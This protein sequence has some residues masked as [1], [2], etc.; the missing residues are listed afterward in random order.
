MRDGKKFRQQNY[1]LFKQHEKNVKYTT[2][3]CQKFVTFFEHEQNSFFN[4]VAILATLFISNALDHIH[5]QLYKSFL[6]LSLSLANPAY[7]L[8]LLPG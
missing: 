7:R 2:G 5:E 4:F 1:T 6:I 3:N 8:D